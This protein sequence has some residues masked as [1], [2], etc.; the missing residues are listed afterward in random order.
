MALR[1]LLLRSFL[2]LT[3]VS[4]W[5]IAAIQYCHKDELVNLCLGMVTNKNETS[6]GTDLLMTLG[7]EGTA[8]NGWM[9]LGIGEQMAGAL[10]FLF[11]SDQQK[12]VAVS[13]RTTDGHFQPKMV[14][15]KT[16]AAEI[17]SVN[18][19][20]DMWQ[21]YSFVCYACDKW[22][23]FSPSEKSHPFLWARSLNHQFKTVALDAPIQQHDHY[24]NFFADMTT[25][26]VASG[27]PALPPTLDREKGSLGT[28]E[29]GSPSVT[30]GSVVDP[31]FTAA[32]A[33]GLL[34]GLAFM[35]LFPAGAVVLSTGYAKAFHAHIALQI[36]ASLATFAGVGV[37]L[38][39]II[40]SDGLERLLEGH[41][42]LG[43]FL[44][45]VVA[46]QIGLGWWHHQN[47]VKLQRKTIPTLMHRWNGRLLLLLGAINTAFG[48]IF[49]QERAAGKLIWGI[50]AAIEAIVFL[51]LVPE[52]SRRKKMISY[53]LPT[54]KEDYSEEQGL[55]EE[56]HF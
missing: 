35:V 26:V 19:Q 44:I 16:P 4:P 22:A 46:A 15:N 52:L 37:M 18:S 54:K 53:P 48:L 40:K 55:L 45:V 23:T 24:G 6:G 49:A 14:P 56:S 34:L 42:M 21:E 51:I 7:F 10:M 30:S 3:L 20:T 47:F 43:I 11:I 17:V 9:A 32:R 36:V 29:F 13:V 28:S 12:N 1:H 50:I 8:T 41:P 5:V 38:W 33:H 31:G 2:V 27:K 39:P 25:S